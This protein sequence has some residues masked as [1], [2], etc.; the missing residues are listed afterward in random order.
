MTPQQALGLVKKHG[1]VLESARGPVPNLVDLVVG[2]TRKGS[3]WTHPRAREV[4]ALTRS[5]RDSP[6]ILV[7]RFVNGH[8][9]YVHRRLWVPLVRIASALPKARIARVREVHTE[10]GAH[11]L[12]IEPFPGWVPKDVAREAKTLSNE[13]AVRQLGDWVVPLLSRKGNV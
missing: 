7:T 3:W 4:F 6:E 13:A 9:T 2:G 11:Q 12:D 5:M 8:I 10:S 1:V